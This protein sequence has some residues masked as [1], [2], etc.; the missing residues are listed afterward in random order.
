M[1]QYRYPQWGRKLRQLIT[2]LLKSGLAKE[3][4]RVNYVQSYILQEGKVCKQEEKLIQ[5]H[6]DTP[7]EEKIH[8]FIKKQAPEAQIV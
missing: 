7:N 8:A 2:G 1:I 5:I 3:I 6:Y 4:V